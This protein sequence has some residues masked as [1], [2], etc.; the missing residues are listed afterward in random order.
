MLQQPNCQ[1]TGASSQTTATLEGNHSIHVEEDVATPV[2]T[3]LNKSK[4]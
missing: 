4:E 3:T 1:D 2:V